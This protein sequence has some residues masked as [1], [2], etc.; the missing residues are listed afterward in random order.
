MN[1]Q[2]IP[3]NRGMNKNGGAYF[4]RNIAP[5]RDDGVL[6]GLSL[7]VKSVKTSDSSV[8]DY[9]GTIYGFA[10]TGSSS[11]PQSM[12]IFGKSSEGDIHL[13]NTVG[14][15]ICLCNDYSQTNSNSRGIITDQSGNILYSGNR[16]IGKAF[17]TTLSAQLTASASTCDLTDASNFPTSGYALVKDATTTNS[18]V[19]QFTGKTDNQLTGVT[20][21][22]YNTTDGT[23]AAGT[24]VYF[25]DDDWKDLGASI[26]TSDRIIKRWEDKV[27]I[28][29]GRYVAMFSGD[30]SDFTASKL[31]LP[32]GYDIKDFGFIPTGSS[33]QILVCANNEET[34]T[35]FVWD[36]SDTKWIRT[37]DLENISRADGIYIA[38]DLGVYS[39]NGVTLDVLWRAPDS[40]E[41]IV[42]RK[43]T[44]RDLREKG[45]CVLI[46]G[47]EYSNTR[48]KSGLWI[49]NKNNGDN[50]YIADGSLSEYGVNIYSI[51]YSSESIV[52]CGSSYN[53]GATEILQNLPLASGCSYQY[54]FKPQN[55]STI[56]IKQV[57]LNMSVDCGTYY[58]P[59]S[60][61]DFDVIVRYY[62]FSKPFYRY[63]QLLSTQ[64]ETNTTTLVVSNLVTPEVGDRIEI[65]QR[66]SNVLSANSLCPRN[67]TAVVAGT[68]KYTLTLNEALPTVTSTTTYSNSNNCS[69][70]ALKYA[71]KISV[72]GDINIKDLTF[73]IPDQP[74]GKKFIFEIEIR[75]GNTTIS[76]ELNYM[77]VGYD[78]L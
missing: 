73:N 47:G 12:A 43:F 41:T 2:I 19:I 39:T 78:V 66:S 11:N 72:N 26:T 76:P 28:A 36:G 7:L 70:Y 67:I 10:Q 37:I 13:M 33:Y 24:T 16:Y 74:E 49:V 27:I 20:K 18:E 61:L 9:L 52:L 31:T 40:I 1:K 17:S 15:Y 5:A 44:V 50:Y 51:F 46:A 55:A 62:D 21:G 34:G 22:K 57:K 42:G 77:E 60:D 56:K 64:T 30:G 45:D 48:D 23:H 35:I 4:C 59:D 29:N 14:T 25:F 58:Y 69:L 8:T 6:A 68:G 38:T 54:L 3:L 75:C 65:V 53:N 32:S 71:G 63:A